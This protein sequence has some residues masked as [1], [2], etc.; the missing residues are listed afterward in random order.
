MLNSPAP[1][2]LLELTRCGCLKRCSRN[3]KCKKIALA[4]IQACEYSGGEEY[5]NPYTASVD[6]KEESDD[7]EDISSEDE[8]SEEEQ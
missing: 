2:T 5:L 3:C 6:S 4:C 7:D 8:D 1:T